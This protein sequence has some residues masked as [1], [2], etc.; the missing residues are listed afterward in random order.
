MSSVFGWEEYL[1][2]VF[3]KY[4]LRNSVL[5]QPTDVVRHLKQLLN[6]KFQKTGWTWTDGQ[7]NQYNSFKDQ[8]QGTKATCSC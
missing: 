5:L 3:R 4:D 1:K 2:K 6:Y 7:S 8:T